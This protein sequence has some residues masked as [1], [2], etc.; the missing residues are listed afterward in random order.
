VGAPSVAASKAGLV[1]V[2]QR[3]AAGDVT[4]SEGSLLGAFSSVDL[5]S[6]LGAPPAGGRP[7]AWVGPTGAASVWYR[8]ALGDLVVASQ[9]VRGGPW[10]VTDVTTATAG[11]QLA[12]DPT[13]A[14]TGASTVAGY[15]VTVL[16]TIARF[17]PPTATTGWSESDLIGG[18]T[19]APAL[20]GSLAVLRA[21]D[22]PQATVLLASSQSGDLVELSDE[23]AG[24]PAG[25]GPWTE[26]DL[27][28][29]GAPPVTGPISAIG[30]ASPDATYAT[31]SGDVVAFTLTSGL[32]SA[33]GGFTTIDLTRTSDL[34]GAAHAAPI[35]VDGPDGP[36]VLERAMTGDLLLA[37]LATATS[38]ADLSF[39]PHTAE[40]VASDAGA[41]HV[42]GAVALVAADAGP[43]APTPLER[44]IA[45]AA[46]AFDQQHR[47]FQTTPPGSDCN[48]FT[49]SFGR[50][51]SSGCPPGSASEEWCSD[52]A[53][54][55][56][57]SAGVPTAGITGWAATFVTWGAAHHRVQW[58]T[59]FR[60]RVGD[61]IVWGQR[62][63]LYGQH[64]AIIVSVLGKYLDVV[65]GNSGGDFPGFGVGVW[66]WG[67]F[68]GAT[69]T[70]YG[71]KV[72]GV[73]QP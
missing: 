59:R 35:A 69:S 67:P 12:G 23:L 31:P 64:G 14:A 72:L 46:T 10:A 56:W 42:G 58:G 5:A 7:A 68:V 2:A 52:F 15:A 13:L 20:A 1:L 38:V 21:P 26:A 60:A 9:A 63:P 65:S 25:V 55:I 29:L 70:V 41:A 6:T 8:S 54:Y 61:A 19:I 37:S 33:P 40:L 18:L 34:E 28:A 44:R 62:S 43:I 36:S 17:T 27:T 49:A 47:G 71:Y 3:S 11:A 22:L 51:S 73:V 48:P 57:R 39:E 45:L 16:G 53:Q 30:G 32:T 50:G 66:R 24:P 4:A